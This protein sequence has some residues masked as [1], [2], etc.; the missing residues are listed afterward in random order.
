MLLLSG[1][2]LFSKYIWGTITGFLFGQLFFI[3]ITNTTYIMFLFASIF[4][5]KHHK[6]YWVHYC[7]AITAGILFA[8]VFFFVVLK[9]FDSYLTD[10]NLALNSLYLDESHG[11]RVIIKWVRDTGLYFTKEI[12]L[13]SFLLFFI[14]LKTNSSQLIKFLTV[15]VLTGSIAYSFI[16]NFFF[17][18]LNM[19]T[20][21][22]IYILILFLILILIERK[23]RQNI[24][25]VVVLLFIPFFASM[26][27]I[28]S[29]NVRSTIYLTPLILILFIF[30]RQEDL[31]KLTM[32]FHA[33][34]IV[35]L[36][37][38]STEFIFTQ[39][40]QGYVI[41]NQKTEL[42][43]IGINVNIKLDKSKIEGIKE[44]KALIPSHSM[45]I[46]G[47]DYWGYVYLLELNVP[48]YYF[49]FNEAGW[50]NYCSKRIEKP[51][52]L[53]LI[54]NTS[55]PFPN[56][57]IFTIDTIPLQIIKKTNLYKITYR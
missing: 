50:N 45:V 27:T 51:S 56:P 18:N 38:F 26:G 37:R 35:A 17:D 53:Y 22:P 42:A 40:W 46:N 20:P 34:L 52:I 4:F 32:V 33:I 12:I 47:P 5:L 24:V 19:T 36:I 30:L 48:Y 57:D 29:F 11:F 13:P 44:L 25:L 15:L 41:N 3:M 1:K 28:V 31:N 54:E 7:A 10:F 23:D 9:S 39:G 43:T 55:Q 8:G 6:K 49:D 16:L 2:S 14:M 21:S